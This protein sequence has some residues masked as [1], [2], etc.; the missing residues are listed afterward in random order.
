MFFDI[1]PVET[2]IYVPGLQKDITI[3]HIT[4]SHLLEADDHEEEYIRLI[5]GERLK[6]FCPK[7]VSKNFTTLDIFSEHIKLCNEIKVDCTVFTGDIIDFPSYTN[8]SHIKRLFETLNAPYFYVLGNHEWCYPNMKIDD[9]LRT[10]NYSLFR[11]WSQRVPGCEVQEIGG[12][13]II[14]LDNSNYQLTWEQ[15]NIIKK[16]VEAHERCVL[17]MHIPIYLPSL[18]KDVLNVWKAPIMMGAEGWT[19]ETKDQWKVR[20]TD[21]STAAFC[22]WLC[23]E[24]GSHILGVF[25]GHIHFAHIDPFGAGRFQYAT[26]PGY[27]GGC[28]LITLKAG[29]GEE[30]G[31]RNARD[32]GEMVFEND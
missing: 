3:M 11:P 29:I 31:G 20:D 7:A 9:E 21:D 15:F 23:Q 17:F 27:A 28:R 18:A 2:E 8:M 19:T 14:A 13:K 22:R 26:E 10:R 4:D 30:K 24:K 12:V 1:H 5:A 6:M 25:C 32:I 16:E